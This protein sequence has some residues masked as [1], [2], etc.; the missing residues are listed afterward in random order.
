VLA[1][2]SATDMPVDGA[3]PRSGPPLSQR[4]LLAMLTPVDPDQ[5]IVKTIVRL[6]EIVNECLVAEICIDDYLFALY[7]RT[8][9][10]DTNK[11]VERIKVQVKKGKKTRTVT[12][13]I[14]KLVDADFTWKDPIA[15]KRFNMS[16]KEYVIGGMDR[17][18]KQK[19]HH[20]LR[21]MDEAGYMPGI[22]SAFRD[23]YRQ[24]IASGHKASSD[25]S[26]HGGSRRG[27]Y[28]SGL[29]IDLVSVRG[30]T[31]GQR[32]R[33]TEELWKWIDAHEKELKVGRPYLSRDPPH[34]GPIDGK[35]F[36]AKRGGANVQK[37]GLQTKNL[38]TK[39]RQLAARNDLSGL[40]KN[41]KIVEGEQPPTRIKT[42]R[43]GERTT[44]R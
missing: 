33:S 35:E 31:R 24:A 40:P 23:D 25:S 18:F 6:P 37:A 5:P 7:D 17:S 2:A 19:L 41:G 14:T 15:A 8:P 10:V 20:A 13:S 44:L 42:P 38:E 27:G 22:T 3:M 4:T 36:V 1:S 39:K 26:Y 34:I 32:Y 16:L 12:K 30:D 29:A 43:P 11:I 9:K 21:Q 28:G